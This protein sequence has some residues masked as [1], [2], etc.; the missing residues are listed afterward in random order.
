MPKT[1][2]PSRKINTKVARKAAAFTAPDTSPVEV[3]NAPMPEPSSATHEQA[4]TVPFENRFVAVGMKSRRFSAS[5]KLDSATTESCERHNV[6][7]E[8]QDAHEHRVDYFRKWEPAKAVNSAIANTEVWLDSISLPWVAGQRIVPVASYEAVLS[9]FLKRQAEI[10]GLKEKALADWSGFEEHCRKISGDGIDKD[11]EK[12]T[13]EYMRSRVSVRLQTAP[14]AKS[15]P[16]LTGAIAEAAA[17]SFNDGQREAVQDAAEKVTKAFAALRNTINKAVAG[18]RKAQT[19]NFHKVRAV[20]EFVSGCFPE[21]AP[22]TDAFV[23][24]VNAAENK[25]E[26]KRVGEELPALEAAATAM[27]DAMAGIC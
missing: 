3:V 9:E 13:P 15:S 27:I 26:E 1:R 12:P 25:I 4:H 18:G 24:A 23:G 11:A 14:V 8:A 19:K 22:H 17:A 10:D 2:T 6:A 16:A 5:R 20:A 7:S 21:L